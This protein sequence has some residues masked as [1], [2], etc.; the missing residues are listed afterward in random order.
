MC[1]FICIETA[2]KTAMKAPMKS[3]MKS[4]RTRLEVKAP[5]AKAKRAAKIPVKR[6]IRKGGIVRNPMH[7]LY[8]KNVFGV[9]AAESGPLVWASSMGL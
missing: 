4:V 5:K 6:T 1:S 9:Q 7:H 2:P 8:R 3:A